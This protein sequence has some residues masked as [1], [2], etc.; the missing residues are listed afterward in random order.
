MGIAAIPELIMF[1]VFSGAKNWFK[2][3]IINP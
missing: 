3:G 1:A 2:R